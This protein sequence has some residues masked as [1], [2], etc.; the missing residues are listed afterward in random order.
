MLGATLFNLSPVAF[1]MAG[2]EI[3]WYGL[4]FALGLFMAGWYVWV[5]FKRQGVPQGVFEE[6]FIYVF[7]GI[8]VGARLGHC[9]FYETAYYMEHPLEML[10][11]INFLPNGEWEFIGYQGMASHGG[12]VGL[13]VTL[14]IYGWR[15]SISFLPAMDIIAVSTPLCGAF[16]R[17]GN[18]MNGEI[19][20][21][22]T[23]LPWGVVFP[24]IDL[25]ARHPAQ[26]YEAFFYLFC[27]VVCARLY[28]KGSYTHV[29]GYYLGLVIVM[30]MAF[31]F[32]IEWLKMPQE[33]FEEDLFFNMG[34]LLSIPYILCGGWLMLR[35][36]KVHAAVYEIKS[37][38]NDNDNLL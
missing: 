3:R 12:G 37:V 1:T 7:I 5:Q 9:L 23:S 10:L 8:F 4:F 31:R 38:A 17:L 22:P 27:F 18:F 13:I 11:P 2:L 26:L 20:G 35:K 30:I 29:S 32:I 14:L 16:I 15:K 36:G 28:H 25:L 19:V 21:I 34:Q 24:H 33:A 6:L